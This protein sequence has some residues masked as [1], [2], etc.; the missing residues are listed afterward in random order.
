[1]KCRDCAIK[2]NKQN[3]KEQKKHTTNQKTQQKPQKH[4]YNHYI[5]CSSSIYG[6][7]LPLWYL[8]TILNIICI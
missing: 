6:F 5:V 2:T 3:S 1:M 4:E 8:Q 7:W